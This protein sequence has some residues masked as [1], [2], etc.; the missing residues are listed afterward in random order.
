MIIKWRELTAADPD[1]IVDY[2]VTISLSWFS[3]RTAT[4]RV[5][6]QVC[7]FPGKGRWRIRCSLGWPG[8]GE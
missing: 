1:Q 2:L 6:W 7:A 5:K 3:G 8:R 4:W